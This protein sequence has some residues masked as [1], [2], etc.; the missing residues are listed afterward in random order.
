M[1]LNGVEV[2]SINITDTTKD[3]VL[4]IIAKNTTTKEE[5]I[6]MSMPILELCKGNVF[7]LGLILFDLHEIANKDI[8]Y[9]EEQALQM[10]ITVADIVEYFEK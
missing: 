10:F 6:H 8:T 1:N 4:T 7:K 3:S 9:S 5:N 2:L